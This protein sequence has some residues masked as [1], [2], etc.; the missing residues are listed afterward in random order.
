M[1]CYN[2]IIKG[3]KKTNRE[4]EKKTMER[5]IITVKANSYN[6]FCY[7]LRSMY[8]WDVIVKSGGC[9]YK[10]YD[11]IS[12]KIVA[13]YDERKDHGLVYNYNLGRN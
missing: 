13:S 5:T 2:R 10:L 9:R 8:I 4:G 11:N 7:K 3:S 12:G 1:L 6:D